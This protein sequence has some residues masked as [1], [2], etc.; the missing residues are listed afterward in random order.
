M[1][2]FKSTNGTQEAANPQHTDAGRQGYHRSLLLGLKHFPALLPTKVLNGVQALGLLREERQ[3]AKEPNGETTPTGKG[4]VR[5]RRKWCER[6]LKRGKRAGVRARLR[7]IASRLALLSIL[8]SNVRLLEH[9]LDYIR[10]QQSTQ[11]DT[12]DFCVYVFT[13][14]CLND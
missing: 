1:L 8:L 4:W 5:R 14:T 2:C 3:A 6:R 11:Q 7:V 9:K 10:L 13:E 12:R